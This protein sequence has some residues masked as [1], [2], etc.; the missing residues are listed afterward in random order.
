MQETGKFVGPCYRC[1]S[2]IWLPLALYDAAN[3]GKGKIEFHCAYGH[4][5]VFSEGESEATT[6][7]RE[8]DRLRQQLAEKDDTITGLLKRNEST[9]K[10]LNEAR[11]ETTKAK[12]ATVKSRKRAA[13]GVCQCCNRLFTNVASHMRNKHPTFKAEEVA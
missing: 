8:R 7:R 12:A 11:A 9:A 10:A 4:P 6:L 3:H 2:E 5:Q 1:K 13:A